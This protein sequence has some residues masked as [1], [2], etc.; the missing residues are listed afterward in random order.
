MKNVLVTIPLTSTHKD[1]LESQMP[2]GAFTYHSVPEINEKIIE[3]AHII[4]GNVPV[5]LLKY[6]HNLEWLQ[7][8]SAGADVYIK[9]GVLKKDVLL[10]NATGAYGLAVSEHMLAILLELMKKLNLYHH[11]QTNKIWK[12]EGMV[13]SIYGSTTLVVGLG[14]IGG[15]FAKKMKALGSYVIGIKR[16]MTQKPDYLDEL[17]TLDQ[18]DNLISRADVVALSLPN[19]KETYHL[20]DTQR[21]S[22]MK[23]DSILIN[24]GRG[25]AI[26]QDALCYALEHGP[27]YGAAIDVTDPEPLPSSHPLWNYENLI[28]TPHIS[29]HYHLQET[30]ERIVRISADNL[31][32]YREGKELENLVDF[33]TGYRIFKINE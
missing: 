11:N 1:L 27:M 20:F 13:S 6:A 26:D 9:E 5:D 23:N 18:L 12:D 25:S 28:I 16:N 31:K 30:L 24:V 22:L 32:R 8:N 2:D 19:T 21:F 4:I 17:Y 10:T 14:D 7:L 29:G 3:K 15:E 33:N